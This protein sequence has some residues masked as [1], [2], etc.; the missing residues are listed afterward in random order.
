MILNWFCII[1]TGI[2]GGECH[3]LS[4]PFLPEGEEPGLRDFSDNGGQVFLVSTVALRRGLGLRA[5]AVT[6]PGGGFT[7]ERGENQVKH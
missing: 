3:A 1:V 7:L 2:R 5:S 6:A 4:T